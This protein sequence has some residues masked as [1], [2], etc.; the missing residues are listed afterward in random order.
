MQKNKLKRLAALSG[1]SV[2]LAAGPIHA[3]TF[4]EADEAGESLLGAAAVNFPPDEPLS[5]ISGVLS[6]DV[7]LFKIFLSGDQQF[8]A[9]T[10]SRDTDQIPIDLALGLPVDLVIDPQLFLLD[11][12][13]RGIYAN[14]DSFGSTQATLTSGGLSPLAPGVHFLGIA[15]SGVNPVSQN[16][17]I[18]AREGL[19]ALVGPTGPGGALGLSGFEGD[20]RASVGRYSIA[21]TGARTLAANP[22]A[23]VPEPAMT[24]GLLLLGAG[25]MVL[26]P[27]PS[28]VFAESNKAID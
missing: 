6:G 3:A 18:F 8:S 9:T 7:D 12:Q 13:G 14:D 24:L 19:E 25:L 5:L 1:L 26:Q 27:R 15:G 16:G 21:L 2:L 22:A 23:R 28:A 4:T 20:R 11:E 17:E 10:R